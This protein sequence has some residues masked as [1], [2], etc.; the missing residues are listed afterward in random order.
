VF[1][2]EI[3]EGLFSEKIRYLIVGGL[4]VNLHGVPR[5]TLDLDLILATDVENIHRFCA[6]LKK[7]GYVPRLPVDPERLADEGTVQDWIAERNMK[8]FSFYQE[9]ENRKVIDVVLVHPLDFSTA[10][11][12]K[13][14]LKLGDA[15]VYVASIGDL[16]EMKRNTGR[17]KDA[18]DLALL[19]MVPSIREEG[20]GHGV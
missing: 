16:M 11:D 6:M 4:A 9:K 10:F 7:L 14:V 8:A 2:Q 17:E 5:A 18:S 19:A 3:I 1:Y 20:S 12:R 15:E 13:T